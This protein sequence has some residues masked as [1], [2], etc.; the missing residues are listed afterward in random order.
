MPQY[1]YFL[2]G[3]LQNLDKDGE[4]LKLVMYS[5]WFGYSADA[6]LCSLA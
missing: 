1:C 3:F 6:D 4:I 2:G 5:L